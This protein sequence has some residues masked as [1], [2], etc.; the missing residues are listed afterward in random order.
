MVVSQEDLR[1]YSQSLD[2][3]PSSK[4]Q[5]IAD[6][7]YSTLWG[8]PRAGG[9][10]EDKLCGQCVSVRNAHGRGGD[11][12]AGVVCSANSFGSG[13]R[14]V[15]RLTDHGTDECVRY[16][17]GKIATKQSQYRF[18]PQSLLYKIAVEGL[19]GS[20]GNYVD[21]DVHRRAVA[22]TT[23]KGT[24]SSPASISADKETPSSP[25]SKSAGKRKSRR[26]AN[27]SKRTPIRFSRRAAAKKKQEKKSSPKKM[28]EKKSSPGKKAPGTKKKKRTGGKKINKLPQKST[29]ETETAK[30]PDWKRKFC[31]IQFTSEC[32]LHTIFTYILFLSSYIQFVIT[33]DSY[34][35][36]I[37]IYIRCPLRCRLH[38]ISIYIRFPSLSYLHPNSIYILFSFTSDRPSGP[39]YIRFSFTSVFLPGPIYIQLRL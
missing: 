10:P 18:I 19:E 38:P 7:I 21:G 13:K 12:A 30:D 14:Y 29:E 34:L 1:E 15:I 3:L 9:N 39:I 4:V 32:F 25:A 33:S 31:L 17:S 36:P 24:P 28:Q 20:E 26:V 8:H 23:R 5:A 22:H 6:F 2:P 16:A 35:H 27:Q 37:P 11:L